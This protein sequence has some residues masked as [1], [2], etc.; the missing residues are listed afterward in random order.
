[1]KNGIILL[2]ISINK[3]KYHIFYTTLIEKTFQ[4]CYNIKDNQKIINITSW[5]VYENWSCG[6]S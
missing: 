5:S 1:M 4:I 6:A 2:K 3:R